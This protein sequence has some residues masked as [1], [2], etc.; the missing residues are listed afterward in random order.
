MF[1]ACR[2]A[3]GKD[4]AVMVAPVFGNGHLAGLP[5][6]DT[7]G[8]GISASSREPELA[9]QLLIFMH[10]EEQRRSLYDD[11]RLFPADVR[12]NGDAVIADG[13]L[14]TMWRWYA[15]GPSVPYIPNL[16]PLELHFS[17]C[18]DLGRRVL[19]GGLSGR[20]AG[21]VA[22]NRSREWREANDARLEQYRRWVTDT[23]GHR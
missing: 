19:A 14:G 7:Q 23:T 13:E 10:D 21:V 2:R 16:V 5:I 12:W 6:V 3:L 17:I 9:A 20:Q 22:A 11:V 18:A 15:Q 1:P 4:V 8:I